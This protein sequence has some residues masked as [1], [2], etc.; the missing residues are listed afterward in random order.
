M[1]TKAA[2]IAAAL[3][4]GG[5]ALAQGDPRS[6]DYQCVYGC[7]LTDAAPSVAIDGDRAVCGDEFGGLYFGKTL[8][9][10]SI[11]CFGKVGRLQPDGVTIEWDGGVVWRKIR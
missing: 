4:A 10:R 5:A 6:G 8:D 2:A 7:R 11:A 1:A 3:L 9:A